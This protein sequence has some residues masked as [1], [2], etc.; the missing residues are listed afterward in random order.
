MGELLGS[1]A[2]GRGV[3]LRRCITP[4]GGDMK[5]NWRTFVVVQCHAAAKK[6]TLCVSRLNYC[7]F[8][9][10]GVPPLVYLSACVAPP[11]C[12]HSHALHTIGATRVVVGMCPSPPS[13]VL[14]KVVVRHHHSTA[15]HAFILTT[16]PL[17]H[18]RYRP[19]VL[20]N[21]RTPLF[22]PRIQHIPSCP[23]HR[24]SDHNIAATSSV[25]RCTGL[26]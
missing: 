18:I 17:Q 11:E 14:C 19:C 13:H 7:A 1:C 4:G 6:I 22:A 9:A 23:A 26:G 20:T 21:V 25:Q 15:E 16:L 12:C 2:H 3:F 10:S 5:S 24:C 8:L